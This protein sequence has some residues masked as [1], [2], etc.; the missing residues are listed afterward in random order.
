MKTKHSARAVILAA[1]IVILSVCS[2]PEPAEALTPTLVPTE[3]PD[4]LEKYHLEVWYSGGRIPIISSY[5]VPLETI[6]ENNYIPTV[7]VEDKSKKPYFVNYESNYFSRIRERTYFYQPGKDGFQRC[8]DETGHWVEKMENLKPGDYL[9]NINPWTMVYDVVY[10]YDCYMH[11]V[12]PGAENTLPWPVT[13]PT[14]PPVS[15]P[16]P[17]GF[18]TPDGDWTYGD[19]PLRTNNWPFV[20]PTPTATPRRKPTPAP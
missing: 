17:G 6:A 7:V 10:P 5:D 1:M 4:D 12:I 14:A 19:P 15:E 2:T 8:V 9:M 18:I 20:T 16:V 11:I 3:K 13:T